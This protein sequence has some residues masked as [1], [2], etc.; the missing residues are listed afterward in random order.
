[1]MRTRYRTFSLAALLGVSLSLCGF[2]QA[3]EAVK[4]EAGATDVQRDYSTTQSCPGKPRLNL[5]VRQELVSADICA[6]DLRAVMRRFSDLTGISVHISKNVDPVILNASFTALGK[7]AALERLLRG[8][9]YAITTL[10][11]GGDQSISRVSVISAAGHNSR[12]TGY[13]PSRYLEVE[14]VKL[15]PPKALEAL[16][17]DPAARSRLIEEVGE[18]RQEVY[19]RLIEQ[20]QSQGGITPETTNRLRE[21]LANEEN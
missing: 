7:R 14:G 11:D 9:N 12:L 10:E 16:Q 5:A 8:T 17:V 13:D 6:G 15:F 20:L 19:E 18:R 21:K 3:E 4:D 2:A 1:M